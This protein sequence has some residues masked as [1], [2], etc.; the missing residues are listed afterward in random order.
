[1]I[2]QIERDVLDD[3]VSLA[4][5]LRKCVILGGKAGSAPLR[6]WATRELH[7]YIGE[8]DL[9]DYRVIRAPLM[10]DAVVGNYQVTRQPFPPSGLP[11]FARERITEQVELREGVG[12]IEALARQPEIRLCPSM[13]TDLAHYMNAHGDRPHQHIVALYWAVSPSAVQGVL[14]RIRTALT[15]LVAEMRANMARSDAEI[16]SAQAAAHALSVVVTGR[17]SRVTVA[18]ASGRNTTA[19][20]ASTSQGSP[21]PGFWT[22]WRKLGAFTAGLATV[23]AAVVAVVQSL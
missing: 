21:E 3:T 6:D 18:Q 7:G 4:G 19:T 5:A 20:V 23:V 11:E 9:P 2:A 1:M 10:V 15:Q 16:P 12:S 22:R 13:A 14:D 17:R 8:N